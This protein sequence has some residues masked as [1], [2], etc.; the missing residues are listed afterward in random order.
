[1]RISTNAG[2]NPGT[3]RPVA[4]P[5]RRLRLSLGL[6]LGIVLLPGAAVQPSA[7]GAKY[8]VITIESAIN[9]STSD[10]VHQSI[11]R[12]SEEGA[13]ALIV[14]LNTP[15]GLL[16]STRAIVT[17]FL[18][19]PIPVVVYVSPAGSQAASAG[20]FI[21]LAAH[22]AAMAPGTNIGAAHPVLV[23]EQMD[24]IMSEKTTNDAAA[25][26]R[27]ISEKRKRNLG[28][29]EDAVRKSVSI[30]ETEAVKLNVV[31]LVAADVPAL[32][33]ALDGRV[34]TVRDRADTLRTAGAEIVTIDRTFQQDFLD[35]IGDP[36]IAYIFMMLGIY[37]LL[38]E[39][40]N[41]GS[42]FPG[43]VGVISLIL[44]FYSLHTLPVNYAG[45]GL[46]VFA[47]VLFLLEIK[48]VSHG[49]LT[50]GGV[51]SLGVGSVMLFERN[52]LLD[53]VEVSWEVI[54]VALLVSVLFF[55]FV[56][57]MGMR[58]QRR[59]PTTGAEGLVGEEGVAIG[60][61]SPDGRVK[62]HGELWNAGSASGEIRSGEGVV[63]EKTENLR[64]IVRRKPSIEPGSPG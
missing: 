31:D 22:V 38:F 9:P 56:V 51:V 29:A 60:D 41:P 25:F 53:A 1:M 20:V 42:I 16:K 59:K 35:I 43:V 49:L 57:G 21:T 36:N 46:I 64:L 4:T 15:G 40:Y 17:D 34:V 19:S 32:L 30:T 11:A 63:V 2:S 52:S 45:I 5:L 61:L 8:H 58:A 47:V 48:I 39:L 10:Y 26:I 62:V 33:R 27:T 28:W 24:S 6:A 12:A 44:A 37:G 14:R 55:G 3:G 7:A 13:A 18:E 50:V 54:G 23:G